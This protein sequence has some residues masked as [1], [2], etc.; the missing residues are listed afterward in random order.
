MNHWTEEDKKRWGDHID[1]IAEIDRKC[2]EA[3]AEGRKDEREDSTVKEWSTAAAQDVFAERNRQCAKYGEAHDDEHGPAELIRAAASY[4]LAD[5]PEAP[6][7]WPWDPAGF[8][9]KDERTNYVRATAMM[10]AAI[11]SGDRLGVW[12][13]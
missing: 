10:L 4:A 13:E 3:Y 7:F 5:G 8:K 11:E 2:Q 9:A 1:L 6:G 12:R